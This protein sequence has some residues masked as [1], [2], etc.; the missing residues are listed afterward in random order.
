MAVRIISAFASSLF[1]GML[2]NVSKDNL[3]FAGIG[4]AL[5]YFIYEVL[6]AAGISVNGAIFMASIAL[7]VYSEIMARVRKTTVTTFEIGALIPLVPGKGMYLT[8]LSIVNNNLD[9]ALKIGLSTLSSA[10]LL[11]LGILM[12]STFAKMVKKTS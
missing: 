8:M 11:A 7:A 12:V 9:E 10:L 2:F 5:G 4:G 6:Q 1:F 3:L